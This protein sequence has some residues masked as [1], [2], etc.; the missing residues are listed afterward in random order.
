MFLFAEKC[1]IMIQEWRYTISYDG[2]NGYDLLYH[3]D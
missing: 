1:P 2:E 3:Y